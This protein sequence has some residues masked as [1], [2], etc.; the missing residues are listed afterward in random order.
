MPRPRGQGRPKV[1]RLARRPQWLD[2]REWQALR[3][4][5]QP[6]PAPAPTPA[7]PARHVL[8][9]LRTAL[10]QAGAHQDGESRR[11]S[12]GVLAA[13][14][15]LGGPALSHEAG[16]REVLAEVAAYERACG[17]EALP[18]W[19]SENSSQERAETLVA[20]AADMETH[21]IGNLAL[22]RAALLEGLF[23][24]GVV[25]GDDLPSIGEVLS[26][27][28]TRPGARKRRSK[29]DVDE[30]ASAHEGKSATPSPAA[31]GCGQADAP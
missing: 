16:S 18:C 27:R 13:L 15:Q 28:R 9:A 12:V 24:G 6:E 26:G 14:V 10:H 2:D 22:M 21:G 31:S 1:P 30:L 25:L 29:G 23:G 7:A 20:L 3:A 8:L 11:A 19:W 5:V 4:K 17:D